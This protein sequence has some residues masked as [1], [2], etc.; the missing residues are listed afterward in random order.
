MGRAHIGDDLDAFG[1]TDRQHRAHPLL[2]QRVVSAVGVFHARLLRQRDGALAETLEHQILDIALF[3][4]FHRGLDAIARIAGTGSYPD[5]SPHFSPKK[6]R[7][8]ASLSVIS[9]TVPENR[10][11]PPSSTNTRVATS[12]KPIFCS[13]INSASPRPRKS[14]NIRITSLT[15]KGDSPAEGSSITRSRG[16]AASAFA[17]PS[18]LRWPPE[19]LEAGSRRFSRQPGNTTK[20]CS[21]RAPGAGT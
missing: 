1:G 12:R 2:E 10:I 4:E 5:R 9:A 14:L 3:G 21:A 18:I 17:M 13:A 8:S 16:S 20:R 19:R 15:N 7:R 11:R 6:A